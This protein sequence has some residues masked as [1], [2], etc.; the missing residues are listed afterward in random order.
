[1]SNKEINRVLD[2]SKFDATDL[3]GL[4][5]LADQATDDGICFA[6]ISTIARRIRKSERQ[7]IRVIVKLHGG[8]E[9]GVLERRGRSN[10]FVIL[11]GLN[12]DEIKARMAFA[13]QS[14]GGTI[15]PIKKIVTPDTDVTPTPDAA[16]SGAPDTDVTQIP[17]LS[18]AVDPPNAEVE[19]KQG[20]KERPQDEIFN[21]V[22]AG[23]FDI[24]DI[25]KVNGSGGRIAKIS[26]WLKKLTP[27]PSPEHIR[28]F[29]AR[30]KRE[31]KGMS[32]P[33]DLEKFQ[34]RWA[35][36]EQSPE[37]MAA[38]TPARPDDKPVSPLVTQMGISQAELD[39]NPGLQEQLE[40]VY[41]AQ[42]KI[43]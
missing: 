14:E 18:P 30:Y 24:T 31:N 17:S 9:L 13:V 35:E 12:E 20:K 28:R 42:G 40:A 19:E 36:F 5:L 34:E 22:A 3:L 25:S 10:I 8:G 43:T 2:N 15:R 39:A 16:L 32:A 37:G 29:Y 27:P 23:S 4:V 38:I 21:A 41:R 1:M 6:R 7:T 33:R 11:S 26:N